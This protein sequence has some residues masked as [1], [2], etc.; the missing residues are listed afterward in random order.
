M[1]GSDRNEGLAGVHAVAIVA[2]C[3][4][5]WSLPMVVLGQD[6]PF[7]ALLDL[8]DLDGTTGFRL[9]GA[10]SESFF[11]RSIGSAGDID[12]DG[13]DD[14]LVGAEFEGFTGAAYV[15]FGGSDG[16]APVVNVGTLNGEDGFRINGINRG[17]R[18]GRA[19][20]GNVDVN[21]DGV[22][23]ILIGAERADPD[24][25][26]DAGEAYVVF[27]RDVSV[28][29]PF[30]ALFNLEDIDETTGVRFQGENPFDY[31]G[32]ALGS[33]GDFDDDGFVDLAC[34]AMQYSSGG[35]QYVGAA[36]VFYG[37]D[38]PSDP[39]PATVDVGDLTPDRGARIVGDQADE[40][41]GTSLV[42]VCDVNDDG[43]KDFLVGA[44]FRE[45]GSGVSY[46][47]YGQADRPSV[48]DEFGDLDGANGFKL[49]PPA[50]AYGNCGQAV[51]SLGDINGDG[52]DD[53]AIG[54]PLESAGGQLSAG[55]TRVVFGR[56]D[57]FPPEVDLGDLDGTNG[58]KIEGALEFGASGRSIAAGDINGDGL[59]DLAI[60]A[61]YAAGELGQVYILYGDDTPPPPVIRLS[62]VDGT[63]GFVITGGGG[64]DRTGFS[65]EFIGDVDGDGLDDLM[66]GTYPSP[67]YGEE[68]AYV[69]FGR[70]VGAPPCPADLDGDGS[71]TI[72]DFLE[73]QNLFDLM[74][75]RA[76]FDGDGAFTIFDFLAFQ[77]A[78]GAGCP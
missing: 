12:G 29:G 77:N 54:S 72:F 36:Y 76:D 64:R 23:D 26:Q 66:M 5:A 31:L 8:S 2:A 7:P 70:Q 14:I 59:T 33:A 63:N 74:D 67:G 55:V 1:S 65:L 18:A 11:G 13:F 52:V 40:R 25:R 61:P 32:S 46:V 24:G 78:F 48:L 51:A 57:G 73:F 50:G 10:G 42:A 37:R 19:V 16:F 15:F 45:Y 21:G 56:D 17:D 62:D 39:F 75:P 41:A 3:G 53:F 68:R 49:T 35:Q 28:V 34:G 43:F 22:D 30:A 4:M 69:V 60:G 47:V 6:D 58:F 44:P 27:G 20:G 71:L 38:Y 9:E